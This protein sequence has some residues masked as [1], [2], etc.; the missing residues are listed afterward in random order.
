M[1]IIIS[2]PIVLST[3][4]IRPL[5]ILKMQATRSA[6]LTATDAVQVRKVDVYSPRIPNFLPRAI[7]DLWR[8]WY[9]KNG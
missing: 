1:I 6:Q 5:G 8:T 7:S 2:G 9:H 3:F 4:I